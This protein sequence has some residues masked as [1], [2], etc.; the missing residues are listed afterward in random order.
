MFCLWFARGNASVA[1][2]LYVCWELRT[3]N[4]ELWTL[5]RPP[6]ISRGGV[7]VRLPPLPTL[8]PRIN[9]PPPCRFFLRPVPVLPPCS[10]RR[11]SRSCWRGSALRPR[12]RQSQWPSRYC[13]HRMLVS[14]E[15]MEIT[16]LKTE[17]HFKVSLSFGRFHGDNL[18]DLMEVKHLSLPSLSLPLFSFEQLLRRGA[19][20]VELSLIHI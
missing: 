17:R 16:L 13:R 19:A 5:W 11:R 8:R 2:V 20:I 18:Y 7:A 14:F 12:S 9:S 6:P 10:G 3:Y 4:Q 15:C 1:L